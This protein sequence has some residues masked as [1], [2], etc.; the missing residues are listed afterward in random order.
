L[1]CC[2]PHANLLLTTDWHGHP[3]QYTQGQ[4]RKAVSIGAETFRHWKTVLPYLSEKS[5]HSAKFLAGDL[6]ALS[7]LKK[8]TNDCS[9]NISNLATVFEE[10]LYLCN[11]ES[12]D[13][14]EKLIL[15]VDVKSASCRT[16]PVLEKL[17][18]SDVMI[19]I[20]LATPVQELHN[21]LIELQSEDTQGQFILSANQSVNVLEQKR[22]A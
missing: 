19:V 8:L 22:R 5:G 6:L 9:I 10:I 7:L 21:E 12:W 15:Y 17:T 2:A 18:V 1:I 14:L 3:M 4:L 16:A 11:T 20:P 13:E